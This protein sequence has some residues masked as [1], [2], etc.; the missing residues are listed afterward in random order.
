VLVAG[1]GR[2]EAGF[3]GFAFLPAT[4][5]ALAGLLGLHLHCPEVSPIHL[6]LGHAPIALV[7][8]LLL[9]LVGRLRRGRRRALVV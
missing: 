4:A 5:S 1:L 3:P 6:L 2:R 7:L 8:P 9:V